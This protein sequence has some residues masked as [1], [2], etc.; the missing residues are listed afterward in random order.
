MNKPVFSDPALAL[1]RELIDEVRL[2]RADL[3]GRASPP[4]TA[5]FLLAIHNEIA[6]TAFNCHDL[7]ERAAM[8]PELGA[9]I[10]QR[11]DKANGRKRAIFPT[12]RERCLMTDWPCAASGSERDGSDMADRASLMHANTQTHSCHLSATE[13]SSMPHHI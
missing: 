5:A 8:V 2:L 6:D 3:A 4:D 9:A 12:D 1:L 10:N 13:L 11:K 7:M